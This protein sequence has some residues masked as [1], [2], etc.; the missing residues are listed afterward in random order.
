MKEKGGS[1]YLCIPLYLI[2]GI[3]NTQHLQT[4]RHHAGNGVNLK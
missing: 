1:I 4:W 3:S 2:S